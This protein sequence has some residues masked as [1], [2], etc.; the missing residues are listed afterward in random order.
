MSANPSFTPRKTLGTENG[1][2]LDFDAINMVATKF[3]PYYL[4]TLILSAKKKKK[5]EKKKSCFPL[6]V[7][8][9]SL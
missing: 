5:K 1:L 3:K 7:A 4:D 8:C 6:L 2:D 9:Q